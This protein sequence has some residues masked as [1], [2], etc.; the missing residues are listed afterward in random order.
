MCSAVSDDRA[1]TVTASG[2]LRRLRMAAGLTQEE[3]AHLSSVHV[4]TVRGIETGRI[5]KPHQSSIAFLATALGLNV[6]ERV[7]FSQLWRTAIS[8]ATQDNGR[9]NAKGAGAVNDMLAGSSSDLLIMTVRE[10]VVVDAVGRQA[11]RTT[12]ELV[13][14]VREG[15]ST[16]RVVYKMNDPTISVAELQISEVRHC[17]VQYSYV[18]PAGDGKVF[19]L[20][21]E[22]TLREGDSALISYR[23]DFTNARVNPV[24]EEILD[25]TAIVGFLRAPET[26]VMTV[27]FEDRVPRCS[28]LF[29][30]HPAANFERVLALPPTIGQT[31]HIG[32]IRPKPGGHGIG[33]EAQ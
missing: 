18:S 19:V 26:L 20:A 30:A 13:V 5:Q 15:V 14:A 16:R 1:F 7:R 12:E 8:H 4:R 6:D 24:T 28:Q 11:S 17:S 3:L 2:E 29:K 10:D 25:T 31:V 9:R 22:R 23:A 27:H 32:I 33:W 21:L